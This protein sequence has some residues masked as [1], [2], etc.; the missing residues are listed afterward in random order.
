MNDLYNLKCVPI[1]EG[2]KQNDK[3]KMKQV[4]NLDTGVVYPSTRCAAERLYVSHSTVTNYC[5]N[6]FKSSAYNLEYFDEEKDYGKELK[7]IR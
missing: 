1:K 2:I 3:S 7:F 5:R 6:K 4:I